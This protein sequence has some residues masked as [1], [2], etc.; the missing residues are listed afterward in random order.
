MKVVKKNIPKT[1][2]AGVYSYATNKKPLVKQLCA[3]Y[4]KYLYM[5]CAKYSMIVT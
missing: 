3:K 2:T 4:A 1:K 5:L